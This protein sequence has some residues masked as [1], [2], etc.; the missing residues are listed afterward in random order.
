MHSQCQ[1]VADMQSLRLEDM[2]DPQAM[3]LRVANSWVRKEAK[4]SHIRELSSGQCFGI[5]DVDQDSLPVVIQMLR[6]LIPS[7]NYLVAD[8]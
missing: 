7:S 5:Y 1:L 3:D 4:P 6:K 2:F 8:I